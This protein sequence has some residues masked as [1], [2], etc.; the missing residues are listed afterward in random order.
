MKET[1]KSIVHGISIVLLSPIAPHWPHVA[2]GA[3]RAYWTPV[4][5][6]HI[7]FNS[8]KDGLKPIAVSI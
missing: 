8:E 2:R 5:I 6:R 3:N 7:L 1:G 4:W